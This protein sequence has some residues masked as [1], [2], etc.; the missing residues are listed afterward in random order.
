MRSFTALCLAC[1]CLAQGQAVDLAPTG[2]AIGYH[3][4][5]QR[6]V[7]KGI[8]AGDLP[9]CVV[10]VARPTSIEYAQ[11][12]GE[13]TVEPKPEPMALDTVFDLASL[14]KPIATATSV[15]KLVELGKVD[16]Q[17]PVVT[18]LPEFAPNGKDSITVTDLLLHVGGLIPDNSLRDYDEGAEKAW[19][20][21]C[22]LKL[23]AARRERFAY[24]DVGFI[25][26][27]ELVRR[28]SGEPLDEFARKQIYEPLGMQETM[29]N[30]P[31][32]LVAR[33]APTEKRD[34]AWMRGQ[35]HDPRAFRL[36]G[37]AGHAGLFSTGGDL[38]RYGRMM[39]GH[40]ED[41][42]A[43][44]PGLRAKTISVM[45]TAHRVP[46]G[47]RALGWDHQSPYSR[48]RGGAFSASAIGH[49]GFTGTV[50][51]I[52]PELELVFI[53]LSNRLHPDGKGSVNGIAGEIATLVGQH[54]RDSKR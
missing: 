39:L 24:T 8:E 34:G 44:P 6:I 32:A 11:A 17:A 41:G 18:Y 31:A 16:L 50:I 23:I 13:R 3:D 10:V 36:G 35:V 38:V 22:G 52:D 45:S 20:R 1:I 25:V 47:T 30:P 19:E 15:M 5:V 48:N 26:L 33:C 7:S 27:G 37:V 14:T 2:D 9:G 21:I 53:F 29:F 51:W 49:G 46:R 54:A 42:A 28:V 12:F 40:S 43:K 4:E